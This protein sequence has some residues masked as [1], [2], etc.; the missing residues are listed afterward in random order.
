MCASV[1]HHLCSSTHSYA[2]VDILAHFEIC[3]LG[4]SGHYEPVAVDHSDDND[5]VF[6][7]QQGLQRRIQMTLIY[8]TGSEILWT[9]VSEMVI[10]KCVLGKNLTSILNWVI[11]SPNLQ[12]KQCFAVL[13][14]SSTL[15]YYTHYAT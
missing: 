15:C 6:L 13:F 4:A 10:G 14:F 2:R 8:E 5:G 9:K 1:Y 11:F 7:L 12:Y 3:E